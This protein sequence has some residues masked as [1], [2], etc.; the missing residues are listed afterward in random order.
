LL[1]PRTDPHVRN[2]CIRFL[3]R[4]SDRETGDGPRM[5]DAR[6]GEEVGF[7]PAHPRLARLVLVA[8]PPKRASPE[9]RDVE[10]KGITNLAAR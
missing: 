9:V 7:Q 5:E 2:S 6:F 8:A 3:P 1:S 10:A 4:V